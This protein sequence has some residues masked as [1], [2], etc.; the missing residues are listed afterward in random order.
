M[1]RLRRLLIVPAVLAALLIGLGMH[2]GVTA[3]RAD[4]VPIVDQAQA[5]RQWI[6]PIGTGMH[7]SDRIALLQ[8][9]V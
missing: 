7:R 5:L 4:G 3:A 6:D 2:V 8:R 1:Q 9:R